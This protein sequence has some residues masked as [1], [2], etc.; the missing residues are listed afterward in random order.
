[1][2]P[3]FQVPPEVPLSEEDW[4]E[5]V[6]SLHFL[7]KISGFDRSRALDVL[8]RE[9]PRLADFADVAEKKLAEIQLLSA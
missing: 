2:R 1:M 5:L 3:I 4:L 9:K 8:R 6:A 7:R